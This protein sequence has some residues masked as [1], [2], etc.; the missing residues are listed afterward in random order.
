MAKQHRMAVLSIACVLAPLEKAGSV[1]EGLVLELAVWV[2]L[3]G[4][5]LTCATRT[6][7]IARRLVEA[8]DPR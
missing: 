3:L 1:S 4:S 5:L 2:V 8:E 6:R 7:A